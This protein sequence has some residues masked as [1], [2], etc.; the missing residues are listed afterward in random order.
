MALKITNV[1]FAV[2]PGKYD[3]SLTGSGTIIFQD[4]A[5]LSLTNSI[6]TGVSSDND[7]TKAAPTG[8]FFFYTIEEYN[9]GVGSERTV[10]SSERGLGTIFPSGSDL[11][12]FRN[13]VFEN[14]KP[15]DPESSPADPAD[16]IAYN[17]ESYLAISSYTPS[18]YRQM[19]AGSDSVL[20]TTKSF[21]PEPVEID[22]SGIL[23]RKSGQLT[24]LT[25]NDVGDILLES[26]F[27]TDVAKATTTPI[28]WGSNKF[29]L[30]HTDSVITAREFRCMANTSQPLS[31]DATGGSIIFNSLIKKFQGFDGTKWISLKYDLPTTV[32][33]TLDTSPDVDVYEYK[34]NAWSITS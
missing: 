32:D 3:T 17:P 11:Y 2:S 24:S 1:P 7:L 31:P 5:Y 30:S 34:D 14:Q 22:P 27:I 4:F 19:C 21:Q 23:G 16:Y 9:S 26:T 25:G 15:G 13:V 18:D 33:P 28:D 29:T 8:E 12:L 10:L 20:C 6:Y